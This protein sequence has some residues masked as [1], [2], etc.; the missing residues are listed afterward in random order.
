M[1]RWNATGPETRIDVDPEA[2][3]RC[4]STGAVATITLDCPER[5]NAQTPITWAAL[6]TIGAALP[7]EVRLVIVRGEGPS[8]SAGLDRAMFT[9]GGMPGTPGFDEIARLPDQEAEAI[10]AEFQAAFSWLARREIVSIA[11]VQG[12][13]IGAGFQLALAC[14]LRLAADD[15]IFTMPETSLGLVPDLG[16]TRAL[17]QLV[18]TSRAL[19]ICVTGRSVTAAEA[20]RI[21][22]VNGVVPA[23]ELE[24]AT[25]SMATALLAAPRE[26]VDETKALITEAPLR[27]GSE[28]LVAER[29][30]QLRLLRSRLDV[31]PR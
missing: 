14:D 1:S 10:G 9:P 31:T 18:G 29:R 12:H 5:R 26:A 23:A 6:R 8:F 30:A 2:C 27:G 25:D 20:D 15:A 28:Q 16:G 22:L 21:G 7:P 19:E 13:A 17:S 3:V 11:M 4:D 24:Q